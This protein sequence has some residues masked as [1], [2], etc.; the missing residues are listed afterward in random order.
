MAPPGQKRSMVVV[1]R[2]LL[3]AA[4]VAAVLAATRLL[5]LTSFASPNRV[6]GA[7]RALRVG[8]RAESTEEALEKERAFA[9]EMLKGAPVGQMAEGI[10]EESAKTLYLGV[11]VAFLI[12]TALTAAALSGAFD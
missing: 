1:R 8:T 11:G 2:R 10:G 5:Q 6:V 4:A 9:K 3:V 12:L 7:G